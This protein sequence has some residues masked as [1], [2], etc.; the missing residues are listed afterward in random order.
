MARAEETKKQR[1]TTTHSN[2][3]ARMYIYTPRSL[4]R[5][6]RPLRQALPRNR[7]WQKTVAMGKKGRGTPGWDNGEVIPSPARG[8]PPPCTG[9]KGGACG[10]IN[11][12]TAP[13]S[14]APHHGPPSPFLPQP[15]PEKR[16]S[17]LSSIGHYRLRYLLPLFAPLAASP[18]VLRHSRWRRSRNGAWRKQ[19]GGR[20]RPP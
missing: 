8:H 18:I 14:G 9:G 20:K 16:A 10:P 3:A 6:E 1:R 11:P 5:M 4:N 7:S 12:F 13:S 2:V 19:K 17:L 15:T